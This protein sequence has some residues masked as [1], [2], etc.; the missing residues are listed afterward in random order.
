MKSQSHTIKAAPVQIQKSAPVKSEPQKVSSQ[1][2]APQMESSKIDGTRTYMYET[3][4]RQLA[5]DILA[6]GYVSPSERLQMRA[7]HEEII[8]DFLVA[9]DLLVDMEKHPERYSASELEAARY[10]VIHLMRAREISLAKMQE[11]NYANFVPPP[12]KR[13][14]QERKHR[15]EHLDID[16]NLYQIFALDGNAHEV[17][18]YARKE[19]EKRMMTPKDIKKTK[20]RI[21]SLVNQ[22]IEKGKNARYIREFL[23]N[24]QE[25]IA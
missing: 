4:T 2:V 24:N 23:E 22:I 6:D 7:N 17:V 12:E 16:F 9:T 10:V 14:R 1:K 18:E 21:M 11:I 3:M 20:K 8:R 15:K 13:V 5:S 19:E 25:N